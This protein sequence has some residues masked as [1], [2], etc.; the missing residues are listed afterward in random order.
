MVASGSQ[1][2]SG[3]RTSQAGGGKGGGG[4]RLTGRHDGVNTADAMAGRRDGVD[5]V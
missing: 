3:T 5:S 4:E 2:K 1:S